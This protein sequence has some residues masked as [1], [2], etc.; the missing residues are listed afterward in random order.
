MYPSDL[1]SQLYDLQNIRN[2]ADYSIESVG[3]KRASRQ[4]ISARKFV[5]LIL[6]KIDTP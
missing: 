5:S 3:K 1:K 2:T 4:L 6:E